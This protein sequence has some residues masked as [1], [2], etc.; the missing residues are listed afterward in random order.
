MARTRGLVNLSHWHVLIEGLQ[1]APKEFYTSVEA[2]IAKRLIPG[3]S[4]SRLDWP[5]GGILSAKRE[6]LRV[7]RKPYLF[8][9]C[10]APFGTGFFVSW[11]LNESFGCLAALPGL[12]RFFRRSTYYRV[13][14][15]LMFQEA[16]SKAVVD[17]VDGMT[18][19]K[20]LRMLSELER[21][22]ILRDLLR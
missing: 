20:G 4:L 22:P 6:Y 10:G 17:V 13:D 5:E 11:W 3:A 12:E 16:V 19:A 7:S 9:I 18:E 1:A 15:A 8:D 2:A 21:K 14:T